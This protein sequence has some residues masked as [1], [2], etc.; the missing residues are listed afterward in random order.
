MRS[1]VISK[2]MFTDQYYE[3]LKRSQEFQQQSINWGG[4]GSYQYIEQLR[5]IVRKY[6]CKTM[7]DYGCGKGLQYPPGENNFAQLIG[8]QDYAMHDPAYDSYAELP[9]GTWDLVVCLDVLPFIPESDIDAVIQLMLSR[10]NKICVIALQDIPEAK[11]ARS[12]KPFVCVHDQAWWQA[13]LSHEKIHLIWHNPTKPFDLPAFI[14][15]NPAD[16]LSAWLRF[17][18]FIKSTFF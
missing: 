11:K 16:G 13:K 1:F 12:K 3:T 6:R 9:S 7:L 14:A 18:N 5:S 17:K 15:S 2:S 4:Y 10:C 8:I